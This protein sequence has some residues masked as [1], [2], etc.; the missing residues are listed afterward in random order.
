M[1][2]YKLNIMLHYYA[3]TNDHPDIVRNPPI[4]RPTIESFMR[5]GLLEVGDKLEDAAVYRITARGRAFCEA[6]TLVPLP[7]HQCVVVWP[8]S[9]L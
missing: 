2:P 4:W 9:V 3:R 6:L 8:K 7:E 5:D 1:S